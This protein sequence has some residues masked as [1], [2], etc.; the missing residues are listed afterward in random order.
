MSPITAQLY[1]DPALWDNHNGPTEANG[2]ETVLL[3]ANEERGVAESE[4]S[5]GKSHPQS[6]RSLPEEDE[7]PGPQQQQ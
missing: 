6:D 5:G 3:L 1:G 7:D 2:N 4:S